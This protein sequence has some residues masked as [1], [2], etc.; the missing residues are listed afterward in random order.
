MGPL[1][2]LLLISRIAAFAQ[3]NIK[4]HLKIHG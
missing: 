4:Q 1:R 2:K 3:A